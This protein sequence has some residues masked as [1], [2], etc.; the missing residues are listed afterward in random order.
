MK[1]NL[2][3][4]PIE[5]IG[6]RAPRRLARLTFIRT[7]MQA[8]VFSSVRTLLARKDYITLRKE[9]GGIFLIGTAEEIYSD[10]S[11]MGTSFPKGT[12]KFY[13]F[14]EAEIYSESLEPHYDFE[15]SIGG[16]IY[17]GFGITFS[18]GIDIGYLFNLY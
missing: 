15:K 14:S 1:F 3:P 9:A 2:P 10:I 7:T 5:P 11:L 6:S 16:S 12:K 8:T 13:V 4:L 17:F 18:V